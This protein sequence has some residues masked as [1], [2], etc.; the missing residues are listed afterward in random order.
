LSPTQPL[1]PK[2]PFLFLELI[3]EYCKLDLKYP[4]NTIAGNP[5]NDDTTFLRPPFHFILNTDLE[6]VYLLVNLPLASI[7]T[8]LTT[9]CFNFLR[10]Y[11]FREIE[12]FINPLAFLIL[13]FKLSAQGKNC[14]SRSFKGSLI[15]LLLNMD[16]I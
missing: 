12:R 10:T 3:T 2:A 7:L 4:L 14:N 1:I 11:I 16:S 15:S 9:L 13:I 8:P 6:A 5:L